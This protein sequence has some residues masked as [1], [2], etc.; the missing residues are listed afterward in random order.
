FG[1]AKPATPVASLATLTA[2]KK[3][4]SVT[5]EGTIVGTFQYMSPE[6]IEGKE[7]DGRSDIFSLGTVLYEMLTGQ[8]A[9]QGKTQLSI[10]SAILE[11]EPAPISSVKPMTPPA[12]DHVIRRCL[13]KNPDERWQSAADIK[14][15]LLWVNQSSAE[16]IQSPFERRRI[17]RRSALALAL[18][19]LLIAAVAVAGYF[20]LGRKPVAN[21]LVRATLSLPDATLI[22]LGDQAGA[23]AIS[24]DGK[25]LV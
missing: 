6:Q 17:S 10:A 25:Y 9:F 14:Q 20:L 21:P 7:L 11:R 4:W 24:R 2:T 18:A 16:T 12:L 8:R 15:E 1:L 3:E 5:E 22:T 19:A 23:P 13:A